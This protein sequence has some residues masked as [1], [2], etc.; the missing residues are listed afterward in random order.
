MTR[1]V[2]SLAL[3]FSACLTP[4][5]PDPSAPVGLPTAADAT[6]GELGNDG[7][8]LLRAADV[9]GKWSVICQVDAS[10]DVVKVSIG[11][12]GVHITPN[13]HVQLEGV[14]PEPQRLHRF[15]A[16]STTGD[17]LVVV[18]Q[19]K[20]VLFDTRT[21]DR[22]ELD[23]FVADAQVNMPDVAS[24]D[25]SGTHLLYLRGEGHQTR[26]IHR[27]L[28]S[29][30][31]TQLEH[32]GDVLWRAAFG[33]DDWIVLHVL[34]EDLDGN[35]LLEGPH[36]ITS[37]RNSD[38]GGQGRATEVVG[39]LGD[40]PETRIVPA[41]GGEVRKKS[42]LQSVAGNVAF[43]VDADGRIHRVHTDGTEDM[44][45]AGCRLLAASV[46]GE[47]VLG[48]CK[49][50]SLAW[51]KGDERIELDTQVAT[52]RT[53]V[54]QVDDAVWVQATDGKQWLIDL[55]TGKRMP[56][57]EGF[58]PRVTFERKV[59]MHGG[60][61]ASVH[62]LDLD[63]GDITP[64]PGVAPAGLRHVRDNLVLMV[65]RPPPP[66]LLVEGAPPPEP[67]TLPDH[68]W[69]ID[70]RKQAVIGTTSPDALA[71]STEGLVLEPTGDT[72]YVARV[73]DGPLKWLTPQPP[74]G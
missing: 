44:V 72:D 69:L 51:F 67:P 23:A 60:I 30:T 35:L 43:E 32:G 39:L 56:N 22:Q 31:E 52:G 54:K 18:Q 5:A 63:S 8:A 10:A 53:N 50:N 61:E 41:A 25:R 73:V 27:D 6:A 47:R 40:K 57:E 68:G 70:L 48:A 7:P 12:H 19:D 49:S 33:S 1:F 4:E 20:L 3:V 34:S 11:Q 38:C 29:G 58:R 74:A 66:P 37:A 55:G 17:H 21:G 16:S 45:A 15:V 71:L 26:A 28:A 62:V 13:F 9:Q 42:P 46:D 24:F 65:P 59:L 2:I 14:T 64:I 36:P